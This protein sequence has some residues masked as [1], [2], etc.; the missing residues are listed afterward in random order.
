[1]S[2]LHLELTGEHFRRR[3]LLY[4][5]RLTHKKDN[6]YYIGQTG[7]TRVI[8]ARPVFRRLAAHLSDR[9][10]SENQVYQYIAHDILNLPADEGKDKPY[11]ENTKCGVEKYLIDSKVTMYAYQLEPFSLSISREKHKITRR[12][13]QRIERQVISIFSNNGKKLVNKKIKHVPLVDCPYPKILKQVKKDF[14]ID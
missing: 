7:D 13:T 1:M 12:K 11:S 8:T 9:K 6:Y 2:N 3:Y 10:G 14:Q 4:I 5:I